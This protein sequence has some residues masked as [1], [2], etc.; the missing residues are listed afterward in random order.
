ME[1]WTTMSRHVHGLSGR[2]ILFSSGKKYVQRLLADQIL[3]QFN[4]GSERVDGLPE[5]FKK[6]A[7]QQY[8]P[9]K[10]GSGRTLKRRHCYPRC[11]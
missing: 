10:F 11:F 2:P 6:F 9:K 3:T 1:M 4:A 5:S 7:A 8:D